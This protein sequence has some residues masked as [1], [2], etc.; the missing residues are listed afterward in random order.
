MGDFIKLLEEFKNHPS[1][2]TYPDFAINKLVNL[3]LKSDN[4][5][6]LEKPKES[7]LENLKSAEERTTGDVIDWLKTNLKVPSKS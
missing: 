7:S 4:R 5:P 3:K 2:Q 1:L 6:G